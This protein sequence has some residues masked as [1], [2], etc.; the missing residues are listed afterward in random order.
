MGSCMA[1]KFKHY[2]DLT[3]EEERLII[4]LEERKESYKAGEIIRKKGERATDLI[5]LKS[6]WAFISNQ[7]DQNIRSIFNVKLH[8]DI[9]GISELSF[10]KYLYD[11][12]A[13][14]D[15]EICPFPKEHLNSIFTESERISR[16]FYTILS[17]EQSLL[18][19]RIVSIGRRTALEKVAHLMIE[20]SA[21]LEVL[22]VDTN[23]R[24]EFPLRQEHVADILGLRSIHV[25]RSMNELKRHGYIEYDRTT[26][27]IKD[28][29]KLIN[30]ANF[31]ELFLQKPNVNWHHVDQLNEKAA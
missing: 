8:G 27:T 20:I 10:D 17:R 5:V 16:A 31:N 25:N 7:L 26:L 1:E 14:T 3:Q 29:Q 23:I 21:R 24:F 18:Y 13:L 28:K 30:L 12:V 6:G 19:E 2:I 15:V 9:I 22:C 11:V 4:S